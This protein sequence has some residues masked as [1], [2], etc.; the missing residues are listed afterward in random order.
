MGQE[1]PFRMRSWVTEKGRLEPPHRGQPDDRFLA[2]FAHSPVQGQL[3]RGWFSVPD[4]PARERPDASQQFALF[5]HLTRATV[6]G[7]AD[8]KT[9]GDARNSEAGARG[10]NPRRANKKIACSSCIGSVGSSF[11]TA[12]FRAIQIWMATF[13]VSGVPFDER[14]QPEHFSDLQQTKRGRNVTRNINREGISDPLLEQGDWYLDVLGSETISAIRASASALVMPSRDAE[15]GL[16]QQGGQRKA[17][18]PLGERKQALCS[19]A[20]A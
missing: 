18:P 2:H 3:L 15:L 1:E 6:P 17:S 20:I 10:G 14:P 4:L 13:S 5:T 19:H 16:H 11:A 8:G 9:R 12:K 7:G